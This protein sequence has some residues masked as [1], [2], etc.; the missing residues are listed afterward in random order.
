MRLPGPRGPQHHTLSMGTVRLGLGW[1][2]GLTRHGTRTGEGGPLSRCPRGSSLSAWPADY[3][4]PTSGLLEGL[5]PGRCRP[6]PGWYLACSRADGLVADDLVWQEESKRGHVPRRQISEARGPSMEPGYPWL[7]QCWG[8]GARGW[9][10]PPER[11]VA[12]PSV[13]GQA[14]RGELLDSRGSRGRPRR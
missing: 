14:P 12:T 2:R 11:L 7:F 4:T 1:P 10:N 6:Q 9:H 3:A 8:P 13:A 5:A